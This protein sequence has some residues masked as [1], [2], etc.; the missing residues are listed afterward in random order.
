MTRRIAIAIAAALT[1]TLGSLPLLAQGPGGRQGFGPGPGR[2]GP[3]GVLP[4]LN[5]V[6]LTDAQRDQIRQILEEARPAD[7]A[8]RTAGDA[9]QALR[10]A[11]LSGDAAAVETARAALATA[12]AAALDHRIEVM[13]KVVAVLTAAQR[14]ELAQLAPPAGRR[15]GGRGRGGH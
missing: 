8:G 10:A 9:E 12:Q 13:Q 6:N 11:V 15:E 2:G 14:Q 5:R 3:L 1:L 7:N 4:G